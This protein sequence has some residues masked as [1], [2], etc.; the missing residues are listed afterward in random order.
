MV[1]PCI[2]ARM[3]QLQPALQS[4]GNTRG[5]RETTNNLQYKIHLS[6]SYV[7]CQQHPASDSKQ[8]NILFLYTELPKGK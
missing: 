3:K 8:T 6:S 2:L 5:K 1:T 4:V 7:S